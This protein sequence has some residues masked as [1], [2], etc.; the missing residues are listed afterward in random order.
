MRQWA[1]AVKIEQNNPWGMVLER[2]Y[3]GEL[4]HGFMNR[5]HD[6]IL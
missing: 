3:V 2:A 4:S 5:F 1:N 6:M